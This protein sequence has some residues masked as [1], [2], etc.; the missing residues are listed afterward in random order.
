[1]FSTTISTKVGT[2]DVLN[3][4]PV[5]TAVA[6]YTVHS[7]L[8]LCTAVLVFRSTGIMIIRVAVNLHDQARP[9]QSRPAGEFDS[10]AGESGRHA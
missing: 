4:V 6:R 3:L 5:P 9:T 8:L 2:T 10:P 7:C 1:M